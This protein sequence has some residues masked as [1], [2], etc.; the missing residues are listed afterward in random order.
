MRSVLWSGRDGWRESR[1]PGPP[2]SGAG[3]GAAARP[4]VPAPRFRRSTPAAIRIRPNLPDV[5][6]LNLL[7]YFERFRKGLRNRLDLTKHERG[8]FVFVCEAGMLRVREALGSNPTRVFVPG[9]LCSSDGVCGDQ[10]GISVI[11]ALRIL[12]RGRVEAMRGGLD[13]RGSG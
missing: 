12:D 9:Q 8:T 1:T 5:F 13:R 2:G 7:P 3:A 11:P 10:E 6:N 4:A